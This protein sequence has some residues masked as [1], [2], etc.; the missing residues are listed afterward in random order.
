MERPAFFLNKSCCVSLHQCCGSRAQLRY[1]RRHASQGGDCAQGWCGFDGH[2]H[3]GHALGS[4]VMM[5]QPLH[6][7]T[8][9]WVV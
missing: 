6:R 5:V 4:R 7:H 1:S 9:R 2:G 3:G 8:E